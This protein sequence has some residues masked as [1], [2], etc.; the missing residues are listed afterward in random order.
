M[1]FNMYRLSLNV[2]FYF[3]SEP[4]RIYS[5][6]YTYP[7]DGMC[8]GFW[9]CFDRKSLPACC[10]M[11]HRFEPGRGCVIDQTCVTPCPPKQDS[12]TDQ[13]QGTVYITFYSLFG[14][15]CRFF[16]YTRFSFKRY[17]GYR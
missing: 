5:S 8:S 14:S 2:L 4:C 6:G 15:C 10:S 11:G 12:I 9:T 1:K 13:L 16:F 3:S 17:Q 7:M